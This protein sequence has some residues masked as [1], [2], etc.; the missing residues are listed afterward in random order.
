MVWERLILHV[1]MDAF[2]ASVEQRDAPELRGLPVVVGGAG[3][4]GVVAAASYEAR[5]F[6]IRSAMP[7]AEARRRCPGLVF[8]KPRLARYREVSEQVFA[9]FHQ[10]TPLV[11]GLSLDEAFLDLSAD[12][13]ARRDPAA[14]AAA[15]KRDIVATTGL[16]ASIGVAANKLVAKIASDLEKPDGL[17]L[18]IPGSEQSILDPLP[19]SRLWGVG[20]Q[21]ESRLKRLGLNTFREVRT[22]PETV[23]SQ[24]FGRNHPR[25]RERA[26]GIDT[27]PVEPRSE[28]RS[29]SAEETFA[30]DLAQGAALDDELARLCGTVAKR[31]RK[32]ELVAGTLALKLRDPSFRTCSRQRSASPPADDTAVLL[33]L[34]RA[35]LTRWFEEQPGTRLRLLGVAARDLRPADQMDLFGA[36]GG[37]DRVADAVRERFGDAAIGSARGLRGK[38]YDGDPSDP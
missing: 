7:G 23:L 6:G 11:Q 33:Q 4:R 35:L 12:P 20:P 1:D 17:T 13:A 22:A 3:P 29:I 26:A 14:T 8:I 37:G 9:L 16:T 31:L 25:M 28:D 30:V 5:T 18:V 32:A 2:Y 19:I 38:R 10:L 24:V 21:T 15:L 34:A 36:D 27:R